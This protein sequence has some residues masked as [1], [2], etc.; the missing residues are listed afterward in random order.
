MPFQTVAIV[1]VHLK[2]KLCRKVS[3][4]LLQT[5]FPSLL[6]T[7][8]LSCLLTSWY[9]ETKGIG[10]RIASSLI[11]LRQHSPIEVLPPSPNP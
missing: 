7:R 5:V 2:L 1:L 11:G 4:T 9:N 10:G 6:G 8:F 3:I